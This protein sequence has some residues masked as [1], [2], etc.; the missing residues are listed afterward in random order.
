MQASDLHKAATSQSQTV[1]DMPQQRRM[2]ETATLTKSTH[3]ATNTNCEASGL[4]DQYGKPVEIVGIPSVSPTDLI[5]G[6]SHSLSLHKFV[7]TSPTGFK[8]FHV[9]DLFQIQ[10]MAL[11]LHLE[12]VC[13]HFPDF[14]L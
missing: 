8:R 10:H 7:V 14:N 4:T 2:K 1:R 6:N 11:T 9:P 3:L 13:K 12:V 5:T